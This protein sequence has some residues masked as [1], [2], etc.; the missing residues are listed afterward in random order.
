LA[1]AISELEPDL[2]AVVATLRA[3]YSFLAA[4]IREVQHA[5]TCECDGVTL[6]LHFPAFRQGKPTFHELVEAI[7]LYMTPFALTRREIKELDQQYGKVTPAEFRAA[8][9]QLD[10]EAIKLFIKAAEKTG[11]N[12]ECGELLLYLLTEWVLGAPQIIAKMVLKTSP[13]MPVHGADGVHARYCGT[14][15]RLYLY[16]GEAKFH[17]S[18]GGAIT[19]AAKSISKALSPE[20][21]DHEIGLVKRNVDFSGLSGEAKQE[22]LDF[23]NPMNESYNKRFDVVTC[24]IGFDF[25]GYNKISQ[26]DGEKAEAKFSALAS[27]HLN[28]LAPS[29]AAKLK[30]YGLDQAVVELFL[31]PLP[32]VQDL[33]DKFQTKIGWPTS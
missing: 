17:A 33:R 21:M 13:A 14:T 32:D 6:R 29:I 9:K 20:E 8:S 27:E 28:I 10:Q 25:N 4:R 31:L 18:V 3:D 2:E 15:K 19:D 11:R 22:L 24:L 5:I 30:G 1:D 23:L 16:W 7:S 26:S 12:G